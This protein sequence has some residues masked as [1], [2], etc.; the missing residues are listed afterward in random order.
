MQV[1]AR[2]FEGTQEHQKLCATQGNLSY[3]M[4]E[5]IA[6]SRLLVRKGKDI[7]YCIICNFFIYVVVLFLL[8]FQTP[9]LDILSS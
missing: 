8:N 6:R 7:V 1:V 5:I 4:Y 9:V 3:N 2:I